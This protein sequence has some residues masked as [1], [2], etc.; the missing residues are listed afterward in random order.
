MSRRT[1]FAEGHFYHIYNRGANRQNIFF[2]DQDYVRFVHN[3]Y[4]MND[5]NPALDF[6][7]YGGQASGNGATGD[8]A[9]MIP[10]PLREKVVEIIAWCF[11]PN[12]FHL[13]LW[14]SG[15]EG[16][17]LFMQKL[18]TAYAMYLNKKY[19]RSGHLFEGPF[20]AVLVTSDAQLVH[21][22]RYIHLNPLDL[23][24]SG[25]KEDGMEDPSR[26]HIFL[27]QYR[28]SS[29]QDW[30]G[31]KNFPSVINPS[32]VSAM[33][34]GPDEYKKFV[35]DWTDTGTQHISNLMFD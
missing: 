27:E 21:L 24:A 13:M 31:K 29:Y 18:G 30:I 33:F 16:I 3:L 25:W 32:R 17:P 5:R 14:Q 4:E 11:M 28:W 35:M 6:R 7:I 8:L 22:S 12:H 10:R 19:K 26:A 2:D 23:V 34:R 1:Q 9:S 20:K 15:R